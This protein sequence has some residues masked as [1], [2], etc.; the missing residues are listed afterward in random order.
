[1]GGI[2]SVSLPPVTA[3]GPGMPCYKAC[4]ARKAY[5]MYP[6]VRT[7]Q[8]G[9]HMLAKRNPAEYF[10]QIRA[11]LDKRAP[12][13]FRWH[14]AGDILSQSYLDEMRAIAR[15]YPDT[16]F[17]AFTK[18]HDLKYWGIPGNLAVV[19]SMWPGWGNTRKNM[20]RAYMQD[21]TETRHGDAIECP[22]NCTTCGM[23]WDL[24]RLGKNVVFPRH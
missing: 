14:V 4:Y 2:P 12:R 5:R 8:D 22:G 9:N 1:M 17:L 13:F 10:G 11:F 6:N 7:S 16:R 18:R 19:F 3:C 24:V 15:D 23:C 20:P 21:G